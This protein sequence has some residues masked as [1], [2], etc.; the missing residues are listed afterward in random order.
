[1][2]KPEAFDRASIIEKVTKVFWTKGYNATSMQDIV[3]VTGLNRSS[4]YNSFGDK[5]RLYLETLKFYKKKGHNDLLG[6]LV[7]SSPRQ[8]IRKIFESVVEIGQ[9]NGQIG[10]YLTNCTAELANQDKETAAF[11]AENMED[12]IDIFMNL[13][14]A[15]IK[16][17]E[18][19][20]NID[21]RQTA[22]FL[23]TSLQGIKLT[24]ML[25]KSKDKINMVIDKILA[26]L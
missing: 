24:G 6:K 21:T 9:K 14:D 10:C 17:G 13:L 3:D 2:A 18:F 8:A 7:N 1:M 22:F 16:T 5:H 19:K 25:V 12:M 4:I 11:L 23:F 15:G 20:P 26:D